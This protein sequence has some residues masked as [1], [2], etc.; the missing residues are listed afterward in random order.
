MYIQ[1]SPVAQITDPMLS[2]GEG[3]LRSPQESFS[4]SPGICFEAPRS[5]SRACKRRSSLLSTL[6]ANAGGTWGWRLGAKRG[7]SLARRVWW[8]RQH[9][10]QAC[11]PFD[12]RRP[13]LSGAFAEGRPTLSWPASPV[14]ESCGRPT[15]S[16]PRPGSAP[17]G[18]RTGPRARCSTP[19]LGWPGRGPRHAADRRSVANDAPIEWRTAEV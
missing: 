10:G 13:P 11:S 8:G 4:K 15:R 5:P 12:G 7:V 19:S 18:A 17:P 6:E 14:A 2:F 16:A 9:R 3:R 1:L